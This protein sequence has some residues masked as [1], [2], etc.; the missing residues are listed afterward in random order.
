MNEADIV[1]L[2]ETQQKLG[3]QYRYSVTNYCEIVSHLEDSPTK[4]CTDPFGKYQSCI[5][6]IGRVCQSEVLPSPEMELLS[7]A[8]LSHYLQPA[9]IPH[10]TQTDLAIEIIT[11]VK[12]LSELTGESKRNECDS[13]VPS[14]VVKPSHYRTLRDTDSESFLKITQLL[15]DITPPIQGSDKE[16]MHKLGAWFL[17]LTNFFFLI[18]ASNNKINFQLLKE[19]EQTRFVSAFLQGVGQLFQTHCTIVAKKTINDGRK[20]DSNDLYDAMQLLLLRS[21]NLLF[22]TNDRFFHFYEGDSEIQ[23]V[24]PG[25]HLENPCDGQAV[26]T[27]P[28]LLFLSLMKKSS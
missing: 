2:A 1:A 7:M 22:V 24:V 6:K 16:K 18:R 15:K 4:S 21:E 8:G 20:L 23:R 10:P 11:S 28:F 17:Q 5:R 3:F 13:R 27:H 12:N 19:D 14:Y 25:S 26:V 9:W